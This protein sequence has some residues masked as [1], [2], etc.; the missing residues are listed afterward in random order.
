[1]KDLLHNAADQLDGI[2][3]K[4]SGPTGRFGHTGHRAHKMSKAG[5]KAPVIAAQ[6]TAASKHGHEYT[7]EFAS[8]LSNLY[9]DCIS[10]TPIPKKV[11]TS[12]MQ[13]QLEADGAGSDLLPA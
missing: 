12:L 1:M 13:N 4:V 10:G 11:A 8:Q 2:L 3:E 5:V 9:E 7:P 6:L